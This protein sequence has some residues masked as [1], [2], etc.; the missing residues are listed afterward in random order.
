MRWASVC[1]TKN[2]NIQRPIH[3][4]GARNNG[5][6]PQIT[7]RLKDAVIQIAGSRHINA[8]VSQHQP[9]SPVAAILLGRD[10]Y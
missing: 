5:P 7:I 2:A 3:R 9:N 1:D 10:L 6:R 8:Y 4:A